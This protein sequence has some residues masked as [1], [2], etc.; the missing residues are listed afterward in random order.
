MGGG[1]LLPGNIW[2]CLETH[3]VVETGVGR[4]YWHL[5]VEAREVAKFSRM[6]GTERN[7]PGQTDKSTWR[8]GKLNFK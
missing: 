5:M 6:Q 1:I 7:S 4:A 8:L 3:L 2:Q